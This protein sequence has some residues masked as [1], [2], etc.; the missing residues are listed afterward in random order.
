MEREEYDSW[1][2]KGASSSEIPLDRGRQF[3]TLVDDD[4]D[5]GKG[6]LKFEVNVFVAEAEG[7]ALNAAKRNAGYS[8]DPSDYVIIIAKNDL[9]EYL[10]Q[11]SF[12]VC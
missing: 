2:A 3:V 11:C 6:K 10:L 12:R 1:V 7:Q 5:P 9:T 4:A 8:T